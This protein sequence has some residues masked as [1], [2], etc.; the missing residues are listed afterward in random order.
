MTCSASSQN[1]QSWHWSGN[2]CAYL[3]N[4]EN[5]WS[6]ICTWAAGGPLPLSDSNSPA[7]WINVRNTALRFGIGCPQ[8]AGTDNCIVNVA[9]CAWTPTCLYLPPFHFYEMVSLQPILQPLDCSTMRKTGCPF[10]LPCYQT[11][12][13][14]SWE[15]DIGLE[16]SGCLITEHD[17][18]NGKLQRT[19]GAWRRDGFILCVQDSGP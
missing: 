13:A 5:N 2:I 7:V 17:M 1:T 11:Q 12:V 14:G 3:E 19:V 10:F 6:P 18:V 4:R 8:T 16:G 15:E 9:H